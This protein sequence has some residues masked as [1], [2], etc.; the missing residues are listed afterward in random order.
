[1]ETYAIIEVDPRDDTVVRQIH[2]FNR[3]EPSF[4]ELQPRHFHHGYWWFAY[5]HGEP[6]GFAGLVPM[7]PFPGVGYLKRA[8][9]LP[10]ARGNG[11][12]RQFLFTRET[13]ARCLGWSMLTA[14]CS[15]GNI[16]SANNFLACGYDPFEPEQPWGEL[17]DAIYW[18]K[19]LS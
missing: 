5:R 12:Q 7:V 14:E 15:A 16:T 4:P 6:V 10:E 8:Y 2:A 13:M 18:L 1:M 19:R 11:L 9:V 3:S 17:P